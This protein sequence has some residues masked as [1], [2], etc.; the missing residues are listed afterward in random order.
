[1]LAFKILR[2]WRRHNFGLNFAKSDR[3]CRPIKM[4]FCG[5]WYLFQLFISQT[6]N[7]ISH[8]NVRKAVTRNTEFT[9]PVVPFELRP[10]QEQEW[11]KIYITFLRLSKN[12]IPEIE[13]E[14]FARD[15]VQF[16]F[17]K[18]HNIWLIMVFATKSIVR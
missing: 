9:G 1:M 16:L 17:M 3:R 2:G 13:H 5:E 10:A 6:R 15:C 18:Y 14:W 4:Q 8:V 11:Q 7:G 12:Y